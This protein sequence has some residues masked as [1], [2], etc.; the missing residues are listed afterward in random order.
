MRAKR[1]T[2]Q[3]RREI[4]HALV[5]TQD[6]GMMTVAQSREHVS[7]QFEITDAQLKQIEEEGIENEWP[8]LNQAVEQVG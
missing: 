3:Q 4:F 6:L 7:K 2:V 1:L 5:S 8:P